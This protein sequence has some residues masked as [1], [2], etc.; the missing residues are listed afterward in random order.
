[1]RLTLT[2]LDDL[3][4]ALRALP[5]LVQREA[6]VIVTDHARAAMTAMQAAYPV[7]TYGRLSNRGAL[8]RGLRLESRTDAVSSSAILRNRAPHAYLFEHGTATRHTAAGIS[9]GAMPPG[10]VFIPIAVREKTAMRNDLIALL[11]RQGF[12][13]NRQEAA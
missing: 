12:T 8:L 6:S 4:R 11:E 13:V 10:R 1:M 7:R 2:G 9:R 3:V 5:E